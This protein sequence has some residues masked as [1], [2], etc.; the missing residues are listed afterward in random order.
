MRYLPVSLVPHVLE[1]GERTLL[2]LD[3]VL[4]LVP[5]RSDSLDNQFI[6]PIPSVPP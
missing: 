5:K 1:F 6:T 2:D 4:G 3:T